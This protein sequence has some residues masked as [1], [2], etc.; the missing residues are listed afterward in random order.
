MVAGAKEATVFLLRGVVIPV[1]LRA[2]LYSLT[3]TLFQEWSNILNKRHSKF[4]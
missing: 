2:M 3:G 1:V 4:R